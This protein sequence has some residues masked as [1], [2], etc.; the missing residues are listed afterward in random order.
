[1]KYMREK[2][3]NK[4]IDFS[5]QAVKIDW[6]KVCIRIS[7]FTRFKYFFLEKPSRLVVDIYPS[8]V[9]GCGRINILNNE[10]FAALKYAQ[11]NRRTTRLVFYLKGSR[12][13]LIRRF[14]EKIV[15]KPRIKK[16]YFYSSGIRRIVIDPGHGG[17]DP[18]AIGPTGLKEKDVVLD[19][20]FMLKDLIRKKTDLK[21]YLT[22]R[23][24]RY[25]PLEK[26]IKFAKKVRADLFISIHV[27]A[28]RNRYLRGLEIYYLDP[29][30]NVAS[31]RRLKGTDFIVADL[32]ATSNLRAS[33]ELALD[34]H[35]GILRSLRKKVRFRS[36]GIKRGPFYV[37]LFNNIPSVLIEAGYISNPREENLLRKRYFR[38]LI[39]EGIFNGLKDYLTRRLRVV[40]ARAR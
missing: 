27:N 5:I 12:N 10:L 29:M 26:R 19:I 40:E 17:R 35:R 24:D 18:G 39:A 9:K 38:R 28:S 20:A 8:K 25:V 7:K 14:G 30:V 33:R 37:L 4:P 2:R 13:L 1:M 15:I 23:D 36:N 6:E 11:F 32:I 3:R 31:I 16:L 22:R 21:V 34:I